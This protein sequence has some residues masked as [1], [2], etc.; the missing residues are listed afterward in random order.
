MASGDPLFEFNA[1]SSPSGDAVL[2]SRNNHRVLRLATGEEAAF[3]G[4]IRNYG[5][6]GVDVI[7]HFSME[8]ATSNNIA[9]NI[10]IERIGDEHQDIDSDSFATAQGSG[11]IAV[12]TTSGHVKVITVSF[13]NSEID[14][15]LNK[16]QYRIKVERVTP[17]GTDATGSMELHYVWG[18]E[19]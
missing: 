9:L 2:A 3:A 10:S 4:I 8:T 7:V 18:E 11:D 15:L 6:G 19:S 13:T 12:P 16:E 5:A 1:M 14:G 17:T